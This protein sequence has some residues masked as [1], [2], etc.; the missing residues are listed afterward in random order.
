MYFISLQSP[1]KSP[2][3]GSYNLRPADGTHSFLNAIYKKRPKAQDRWRDRERARQKQRED[4]HQQKRPTII[5]CPEVTQKK[6]KTLLDGIGN[7][8][9]GFD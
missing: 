9:C 8:V 7:L 5:S 6:L 4:S 2:H 1:E 3:T